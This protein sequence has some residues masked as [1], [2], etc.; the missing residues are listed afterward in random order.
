MDSSGIV[1]PSASVGKALYDGKLARGEL[2]LTPSCDLEALKMCTE[3]CPEVVRHRHM[4]SQLRA[5]K[6]PMRQGQHCTAHQQ[7]EDGL[8]PGGSCE[9]QW[10]RSPWYQSRKEFLRKREVT[11]GERQKTELKHLTLPSLYVNVKKKIKGLKKNPCIWGKTKTKRCSNTILEAGK[12]TH[13]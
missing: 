6:K 5:Q 7:R 8:R 9:V 4:G 1:S 2:E 13:T 3:N 12:Q 10:Q 11:S